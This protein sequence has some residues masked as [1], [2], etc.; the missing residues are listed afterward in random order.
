MFKNI[1]L[2]Q[3]S[4]AVDSYTAL[5]ISSKKVTGVL[6]NKKDKTITIDIG[7]NKAMK[8]ELVEDQAIE[9]GQLVLIDGRN[10]KNSK[11]FDIESNHDLESFEKDIYSKKL[12]ELG[13]PVNE[14]NINVLKK[15]D[16]YGV[17]ISK[18]NFET[19]KLAKSSLS[20]IESSLDYESAIKLVEMDIDL[21]NESIEK[22][23]SEIKALK[24][25]QEGRDL[26]KKFNKDKL[27]TEDAEA[28]AKEIYG[29]KMGK[30]IIDIIKSLHQAGISISKKN[31]EEIN[32]VFYK[33]N[34]LREI[35]DKTFVDTIKNNLDINIDNLY[36]VKRYV[37]NDDLSEIDS[38]KDYELQRILEPDLSSKDLDLLDQ[39]IVK[40]L[41]SLA[42]P[43]SEENI[44]IAKEFIKKDLDITSERIVQVKDFRNSLETIINKL[45]KNL[46][47][48][49]LREEINI[50]DL[51]IREL[52][53]KIF[54]L[55]NSE[56]NLSPDV[57]ADELESL[58]EKVK[59]L[60]NIEEKDIISLLEKGI[61]F[62]INKLQE[63]IW[64]S[65]QVANNTNP[66]LYGISKISTAFRSIANL[67]FNTIAFQI[68]R[69]IPMTLMNMEK[70]QLNL[71][72]SQDVAQALK[73]NDLEVSRYNI[74]KSMRIYR[75]FLN[76]KENLTIDM[77]KQA[78]ENDIELENINIELASKHVDEYRKVKGYAFVDN[79]TEIIKNSDEYL[80]FLIKNKKPLSFAELSKTDSIFKNENQLGHKISQMSALLE[81]SGDQASKE[82]FEQFKKQ[83][84]EISKSMSASKEDIEKAYKQIEKSIK[85]MEEDIKF[86]AKQESALIKDKF[87]EL[88]ENID[89][90]KE[91][92]K[93]NKIIQL[94]LYMNEQFTNLNMYFRDKGKSK[95]NPD[96]QEISAV[97]SIDTVNLGNL[98]IN[99]DIRGRSVDI[100][101]VLEKLEDKSH[102]EGYKNMLVDLL[103]Q[104]GY[105]ANEISFNVDKEVEF[106]T[107]QETIRPQAS[108]SNGKLDISI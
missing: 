107:L 21:E 77:V 23:A 46:A 28:I 85:D 89:E 60:K 16:K 93:E 73:A 12:K 61:D 3:Y 105:Q 19:Y 32:D 78:R 11:I 71:Q 66:V 94:P 79:S 99:L 39:E 92:L 18:E 51:D 88:S 82:K 34:N 2:N 38:L 67:D 24:A 52:A 108:L 1:A 40:L 17:A 6:M 49:L 76:I 8:I 72:A 55:E 106:L 50:E 31:I 44:M 101:M 35:E 81:E 97:L 63:V 57:Q 13:L 33:L 37:K 22:I 84:I 15:L 104:A 45:D 5:N 7:D 26:L 59:S 56:S 98:N 70:S 91:I 25:D 69:S 74:Q 96:R 102:I 27:T 103:D 48:Q 62:K 47:A 75:S 30:D 87:R 65:R 42:L 58:M 95:S 4:N 100:S 54:E 80:M 14:R 43:A 53:E 41:E 64:S 20:D 68:K 36:K 9:N 90:N 29:S 10:I 83:V 86:L